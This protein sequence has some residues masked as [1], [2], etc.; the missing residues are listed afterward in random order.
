M[1]KNDFKK[2][3]NTPRRR[4]DNFYITLGLLNRYGAAAW[5]LLSMASVAVLIKYGWTE[6]KGGAIAAGLLLLSMPVSFVITGLFDLLGGIF[7]WKGTL[8]AMQSAHRLPMEPRKSWTPKYR[9][10]AIVTGCIFTVLGIA[11]LIVW[12]LGI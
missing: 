4:S 8:C 2:S 3:G 11:L 6:E 5:M 7:R 1:K 9:R 12:I 10:D